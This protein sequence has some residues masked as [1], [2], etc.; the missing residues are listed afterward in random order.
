MVD[1]LHDLPSVQ[2]F[3]DLDLVEILALLHHKLR[4]VSLSTHIEHLAKSVLPNHLSH[5]VSGELV[6][7]ETAGV[8]D[9]KY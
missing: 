9:H 4:F 1:G 7:S 3:V 2:E 6:V 5:C 8:V